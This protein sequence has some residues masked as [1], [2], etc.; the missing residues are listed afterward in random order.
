MGSEHPVLIVAELSANHHQ[1]LATARETIAAAA[2]AGADAI[3]LQTYTPETI[4]FPSSD[5]VFRVKGGSVWDG[6]TLFDLYSEAHTPWEWHE[7]LFEYARSLGLICF[8][9]PFDPSAIDLLERLSTPAYK[10][11]SFEITDTPLI[12]LMAAT[13]QPVVISTGIATLAEIDRALDTCLEVGNDQVVLLKCTSAYP[14]ALSEMNLRTMVDMAEKFGSLVGLSD[15]TTGHTASTAATA[16]GACMIEKHLTLDR[17]A[18]GPD[19]GFSLEPSEFAEMV[20]RVRDTETAL[21]TV[22][23]ELTPGSAGNRQFARSLFVVKDVE[24][25]DSVNSE[26]VR[27]IRP[28]DG[29]PPMLLPQVTN[30][31]FTEH[32]KA[33]TPLTWDFL[34]DS[35]TETLP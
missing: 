33:G 12:R 34:S 9:S 3:K 18:G 11:A 22:N 32:V 1:S 7:E 16:L 35:P 14:A 5:E 28:S 20:R 13:G 26:N 30:R 17:S 25:G 15:H 6:R 23:Y 19:S 4:T 21:G 31:K 24:P 27:S 8:S 2:A 29:L 10:V